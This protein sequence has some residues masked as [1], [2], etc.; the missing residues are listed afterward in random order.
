MYMS[1]DDLCSAMRLR[2]IITIIRDG[3]V[4]TGLVNGIWPESGSG[5]DWI[6][7]MLCNGQKTDVYVKTV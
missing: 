1:Y 4:F 5:R 7:T 2:K 6:V 3:Q